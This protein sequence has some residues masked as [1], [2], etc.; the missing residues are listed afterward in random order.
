MISYLEPNAARLTKFPRLSTTL[1][2]FRSTAGDGFRV[3]TGA[4]GVGNNVVVFC[5]TE[6]VDEACNVCE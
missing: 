4:E 6:M 5:E 3:G 1:F 2:T